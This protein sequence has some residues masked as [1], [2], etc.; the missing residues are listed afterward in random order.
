MQC[1][2]LTKASTTQ[3][4]DSLSQC[5]GLAIINNKG[6]LWVQISDALAP[7][8]EIYFDLSRHV[9]S[10]GYPLEDKGH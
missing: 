6:P 10:L 1:I 2:D 5:R 4:D 3:R 7:V 9:K 8:E